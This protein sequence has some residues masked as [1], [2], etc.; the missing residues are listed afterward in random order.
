MSEQQTEFLCNRE[1]SDI[2]VSEFSDHSDTKVGMLGSKQ[3]ANSDYEE[4]ASDN[5]D[6]RHHTW[7]RVGTDRLHFPF[8]EK[9][10]INVDSKD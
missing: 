9:R 6:M 5:S 2:S 10:D 7:P 1:T 8:S 3:R 4:N